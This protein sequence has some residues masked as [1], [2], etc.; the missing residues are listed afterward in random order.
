MPV[1]AKTTPWR[2][3]DELTRA[4]RARI[5]ELAPLEVKLIIPPTSGRRCQ[6]LR[7]RQI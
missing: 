3:A 1:P 5:G 2:R 4:Q 6:H 7:K